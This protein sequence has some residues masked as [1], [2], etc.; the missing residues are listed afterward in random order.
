MPGQLTAVRALLFV[1]VAIAAFGLVS[2]FVLL[3]ASGMSLERVVEE[4]GTS[5][6]LFTLGLLFGVGVLVLEA[7]VAVRMGAGGR[8]T[9]TLLRVA[10]IM[11]AVGTLVNVVQGSGFLGFA[12]VVVA[13]VL[14]ETR[15]AKDWFEDTDSAGGHAPHRPY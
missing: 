9:Q 8:R 7:V 5:M 15:T 13:L 10:L 3:S 14:A 1:H 2:L 6:G 12:L 11:A 4:T